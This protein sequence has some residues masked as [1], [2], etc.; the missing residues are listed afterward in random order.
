VTELWYL[1]YMSFTYLQTQEAEAMNHINLDTY[2]AAIKQFILSL[3]S[4]PG[5]SVLEVAGQPVARVLPVAVTEVTDD[6]NAAKN[7]RRC[8][9]IDREIAGT[10][11][12][13]E[14]TELQALQAAMLRHRRRVA[15]LPLD[16]ARRLHQELLTKAASGPTA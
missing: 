15:P 14:A 13:E 7:T 2:D 9:L 3:P 1:D 8:E 5:G 11:T 4:D 12:T 6:W 10:L 16:E